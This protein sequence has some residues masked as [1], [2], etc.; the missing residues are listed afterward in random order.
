M[1]KVIGIFIIVI[2]IAVYIIAMGGKTQSNKEGTQNNVN[3]S[4]NS[5]R[6]ITEIEKE[7]DTVYPEKPAKVVAL[8][9]ELMKI[10]YSQNSTS[11]ILED[12]ARAIRKIY[13]IELQN[14]NSLETQV[15]DLEA[16]KVYIDS[17]DMTLVASEIKEVYIS[18]D[19]KGHEN[20]AEVNVI[21]ATNQGTLYRTYFLVNEEGLWKINAWENQEAANTSSETETSSVTD[22]SSSADT[23]SK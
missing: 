3:T 18:K 6:N 1:R 21:H 19:D 10:F 9:N 4:V 17:I 5:D 23:E 12:Y 7:I 22:T 8:H 2:V 11:E 13:S 20:K 14:L 16:E 15:K